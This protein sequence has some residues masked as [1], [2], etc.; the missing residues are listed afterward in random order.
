M[1]PESM[2][3]VWPVMVSVRHMATTMSA[4]SSLSAGF[5]RSELDAERSICSDRRLAVARVP[6]RRPGATQLTSVTGAKATAMQRVIWMKTKGEVTAGTLDDGDLQL[7]YS[8]NILPYWD[9]QAGY[10]REF[11][12][13]PANQAV[14]SLQGIAP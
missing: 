5:F 3:T 7:Q 10:R 9:L 1:R 11:K 2:T 4:Q 12:P 14:I 13:S 8:R 6:S